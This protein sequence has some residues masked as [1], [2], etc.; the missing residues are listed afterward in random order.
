MSDAT[1]LLLL[2]IPAAIGAVYMARFF[3]RMDRAPSLGAVTGAIAGSS[4]RWSS[5]CR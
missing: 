1:R 4:A 2:A 5:C 3:T